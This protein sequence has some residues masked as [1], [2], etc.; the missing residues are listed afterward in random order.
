MLRR[1]DAHE[2]H[3]WALRHVNLT[4][5]P[6]ESLAVIGPNGAGKS[7]LLLALA[8]ILQ[9]S[10]GE[11][12]TN[13]RVSTLLTLGAGFE[14]DLTGRDNIDLA[15]A[16]LGIHQ[17]LMDELTPSI[18]EFAD[19]G[20]FIDAPV[21]TYSSG[22]RARLGLFDRDRDHARHP[23]ARTPQ[24]SASKFHSN[25]SIIGIVGPAGSQ[26]IEAVGPIF[27]AKDLAFISPSATR[28]SL[29][30]VINGKLKY[31]TFF[32]V[33]PNDDAQ[34]PTDA[35]FMLSKGAKKAFVVDDQ[36]SYSTGL[37]D[38]VQQ[39]LKSK[40]VVRSSA[41][42]STRRRRTSRRWS[43][44]ISD[45]TAAVFLPWQIAADAQL[46]AQPMRADGK[47]ATLFGSDGLFSP[48]TSPPRA[49]TSRRSPRTSSRSRR[50]G[51][52][53]RVHQDSTANWD[54]SARP[55]TSPRWVVANAMKQ[56]CASGGMA[57]PARRCWRAPP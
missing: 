52:R 43:S 13:G 11:I 27:R 32:R 19:I 34:G 14:Q 1:S 51:P 38:K 21:K 2:N 39:V 22:M 23:A 47:K 45:D 46:F 31:P 40:G 35:N 36:E 49:P 7:T 12:E 44:K 41:S 26:E 53:R 18:I 20:Q 10:E 55:S 3:F 56:A 4:L 50:T 29:T 48:G 16:F 9:P 8:G 17:S 24:R 57:E 28:T 25:P 15:G 6:G 42:P 5:S 37:A 54:S 33:V 30:A